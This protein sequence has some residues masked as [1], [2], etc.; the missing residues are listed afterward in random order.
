MEE[1][2]IL[3]SEK[4]DINTKIEKKKS[5]KIR[6]LGFSSVN[7]PLYKAGILIFDNRILLYIIKK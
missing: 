4:N 6:N 1:D 3:W 2:L 5:G 7:F